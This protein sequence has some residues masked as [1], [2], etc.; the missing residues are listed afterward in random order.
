MLAQF[1]SPII[2]GE[3]RHVQD[4]SAE[5]VKRGHDVAIATLHMPGRAEFEMNDG[6]R[7]YRVKGTMQRCRWLYSQAERSHAPPFPDPEVMLGLRRIIA[8]EQPQIIHAHNWML[9]SFLPLKAWS[10][11]PLVL[12]LHEYSL[13]CVQKRLMRFGVPCRGP[14]FVKCL[15]CA[16][17]HYG[18]LKG[19]VTTLSHR[20]M[21]PFERSAVDIFLPVSMA[22]AIGNGLVENQLPFEIIPNFLPDAANSRPEPEDIDKYVSQ[23]P[24]DGYLLFVG[25]LSLDK[26]VSVLL[27]AYA[28]LRNPPPLVLIG[29]TIKNTPKDLPQNVFLMNSWPHTAVMEAWRRSSIALAPSIWSEPFGIVA[30]EA[31]AMGRPVIASRMGGLM[32]IISDGETGFLIPPGDSAS[33]AEAIQRLLD[34]KSLRERM[35]QGAMHRSQEFRASV[36]VPRIEAVYQRL[37]QTATDIQGVNERQYEIL[38]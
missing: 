19:S 24:E 32:D 5:L 12:S 11:V 23:L 6:L 10:G 1:Y 26:G 16:S 13:V 36:V 8:R 30:I 4:L 37:T 20:M 21:L 3:E 34:D 2:G 22:T 28:D 14:G 33:L 27:R 38:S 29:R 31:M 9:Y 18:N 35:G 17:N 25:D 15:S 7:V